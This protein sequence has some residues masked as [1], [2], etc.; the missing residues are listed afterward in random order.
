MLPTGRFSPACLPGCR[1]NLRTMTRVEYNT[2]PDDRDLIERLQ[3][4]D[5]EACTVCIER[6]SPRIYRL[7]LRLMKNEADAE[8]VLQETFLSAFKA[9]DRFEGRSNLGTWL[10]RIAYNA[11]MM[12][13]RRANPSTLSVDEKMA[14]AEQGYTLPRQLFDWCC[15]PEKEFATEEVREELERALGTLS[16]AL[17]SAFVLR[18]M[19]GLSTKETAGIL[20]ISPAAVKK[21]LQRARID[22]REELSNYFAVHRENGNGSG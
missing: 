5:R 19:E 13:L 3:A 12:R 7:A 8:D 18:E 10:Y 14:E 17:R 1:Y 16:P 11:A 20:D 4:G 2:D 9:I 21:R 6:Y 15:L 22:L